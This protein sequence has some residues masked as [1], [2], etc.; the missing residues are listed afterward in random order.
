MPDVPLPA[1]FEA[2][3]GREPYLF[4][5]YAHA[6][7]A[8]IYPELTYLRDQG[9]RIWYDEGIH[10][11]S[12]WPEEVAKALAAA[13]FFL[14]FI[15]PAAVRSQNVR[16]EIHYA[17]NNRKPFLAIHIEET[18]LPPGLELRMGDIHAI[19]KHRMSSDAYSRK[20]ERTLPRSVQSTTGL[21]ERQIEAK[22]AP[23]Q[24][25]EPRQMRNRRENSLGNTL[26]LIPPEFLPQGHPSRLIVW[27][28]A[29]CVS[30]ADYLQFV[31][32]GGTEPVWEPEYR[33]QRPWKF[34]NCPK[35][36][37]DHPVVFV[38]QKQAPVLCVA[39]QEGA[40]KDAIGGRNCASRILHVADVCTLG[41]RGT[42][43]VAHGAHSHR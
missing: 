24:V 43:C 18:Q 27:A 12:E 30:N 5:S 39:H 41:R 26:I 15:S 22:A 21:T 9:Y 13:S 1:P 31:K 11:G 34:K 2:Y 42:K 32:D 4:A 25:R 38:T 20:I 3:T 10:P 8:I 36:I 19:M 23:Q 7:G 40:G 28:S 16:N 14:V 37:L 33:K 35:D 17:L 29:T 6:D